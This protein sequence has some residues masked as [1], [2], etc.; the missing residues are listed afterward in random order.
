MTLKNEP[1]VITDFGTKSKNNEFSI[2]TSLSFINEHK[3]KIENWIV[4]KDSIVLEDAQGL[5]VVT[6]Y[7]LD[8]DEIDSLSRLSTIKLLLLSESSELVEAYII[9]K[10]NEK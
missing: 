1:S 5:P 3:S 8:K 7:N 6:F 9:E 4:F 10:K 2:I